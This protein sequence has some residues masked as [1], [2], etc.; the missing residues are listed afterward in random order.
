MGPTSEAFLPQHMQCWRRLS[1]IESRKDHIDL[2]SNFS[3]G[4]V[5]YP[6]ET[7]DSGSHSTYRHSHMNRDNN[8]TTHEVIL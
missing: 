1:G 4:V 2:F 5:T 3:G 6:P 8:P 7:V